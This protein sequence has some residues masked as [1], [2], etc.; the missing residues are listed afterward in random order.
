MKVNLKLQTKT[1]IKGESKNAR[2]G[3][4]KKFG[5]ETGKR[6][7]KKI[8]KSEK[9]NKNKIIDHEKGN[10]ITRILENDKVISYEHGFQ[11]TLILNN[12]KHFEL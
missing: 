1:N 11:N 12:D 4:W 5:F 8:M 7:T 10:S 3:K 9:M 2:N 6:K